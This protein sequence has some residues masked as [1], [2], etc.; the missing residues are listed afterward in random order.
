MFFNR[1]KIL[2]SFGFLIVLTG[3]ALAQKKTIILVRHAEKDTIQAG[4]TADPELSEAG[5]ERARRFTKIVGRY[6][7]GAFYSTDLKR[8]RDTISDL[9]GKR[10]K[11]I[12][13]YDPRKPDELLGRVMSDRNKR[14]VISGHSNTIPALANLIG[15]K[16]LFQD[17]DES[18][19][20]VIWVIRL[21]DGR[22]EKIELLDY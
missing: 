14:I 12:Q 9:A 15:R 3:H 8:T 17:L 21:K 11:Q 2:L 20:S 13:T 5:R 4:S 22:A 6:R 18:E 16:E 10:G 7:P 1:L 19:Y